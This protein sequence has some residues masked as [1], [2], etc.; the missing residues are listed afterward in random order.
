MKNV[1]SLGYIFSPRLA[2]HLS[3]L[4]EFQLDQ[5]YKQ[6]VPALKE[7]R[8]AHRLFK[9]IY[10]NFPQQVMDASAYE[11]YANAFLHY[12]SFW[13]KDM[14]VVDNTW[15]PSYEKEE[16]PPLTEET[17]LD[18]IDLGSQKDFES[19]FGTLLSA[20]SS[21]SQSD[22]DV[23]T[24]F[25]KN[26][27][28]KIVGLLPEAVPLKE[29]LGLLA[30]NLLQ[31]T[32][33]AGSIIK[34]VKTATDVLRIAVALSGGD[35]SLSENTK[36]GKFNRKT[37]RFLLGLL[38]E[39]NNT[40]ED[41]VKYHNRWLRLG[42]RLHPGEFQSR[43]PKA[44]E[45][46]SAH[47]NSEKIV[48]FNSKVESLLENDEVKEVSELLKSRPGEFA[49][50]LD[51]IFRK[52]SA[53]QRIAVKR[54]FLEVADKVSTPVLLQVFSHFKNRNTGLDFRPVFPKGSLAKMQVL[55]NDLEIL[56]DVFCQNVSDS[57]RE[58]LEERFAALPKLGKVYLDEGLK[59]YLVPF[60]QR[61]ASK[62]LKTIVRGS[63]V[64]LDGDYDTIRF[65]IWWKNLEGKQATDS[66]LGSRV[67]I[68]LSAGLLN[69]D[70]EGVEDIA[71]YNLKAAEGCHSGD[72]T[73]A[74][75]GACEFIDV[76]MQSVLDRGARYIAMSVNS[77]TSTPL[78]DLPECFAGWMGREKPKSGEIFDAK[79]VKNKID[80][81]ANT[82]ACI[83][84]V[85][86]CLERKVIWADLSLK[87][88]PS[89]A[90]TLYGNKKNVGLI[91]KAISQLK[92][93][94]LYDLLS[95]HAKGRGKIVSDPKKADVVFSQETTPFE[96]DKIVS[97]Y[98]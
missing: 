76:S 88:K 34:Y 15:L 42:E 66:Y 50:R 61:S 64:D 25:V 83:P 31:N 58:L 3:T 54:R 77:Y 2:K 28:D 23:V 95:M 70:F 96:V 84:L 13:L 24:W 5:M 62:A 94:N 73:D 30:A 21:I 63:K 74:P 52:G 37:R 71:F 19:I 1:E 4:T 91:C 79:T 48:T 45:A 44:Y 82:T 32:N 17:K 56:P 35:V 86:D 57:V 12:W 6:I 33:S 72:I 18:V 40:K 9:P 68:D 81:S 8:G 97:E 14:G 10:P 38:E 39:T 67:D 41:M 98:L 69:D 51:H 60:S 87:T 78:C 46:F 93:A 22:K 47:R 92:K 55:K 89:F 59:N 53:Q 11:L 65:F 7:M 90:N 75:N 16:R 80:L 26:Y 27:S 85:I 36:F 49:R 29:N 43:Y 20:K